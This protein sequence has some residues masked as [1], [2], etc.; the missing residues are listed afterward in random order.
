[1]E[2]HNLM[3]DTVSRRVNELCDDDEENKRGRYCTSDQCRLD[4]ICY[5]LN[6]IQP[7]YVTSSRGLA[8]MS[9]DMENNQQLQIDITRLAQEGLARVSA[10]QRSYY[11][12]PSGETNAEGPCFNFPTIKGRILNGKSFEAE[13]GFRVSLLIDGRLAE[14]Y[15]SR[16]QNPYEVVENA[17]GTFI[18]WPAPIATEEPGETR[19]FQCELRVEDDRFEE[20]RHFFSLNLESDE[21]SSRTFTYNSDFNLRDMYIFPAKSVG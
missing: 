13:S 4:A 18:F 19:E 12:E 3:E 6:R 14:M 9:G 15:D 21:Q 20:F 2:I 8:H 10:I 7:H 11:T 16:W 1:M 17:P 5:V